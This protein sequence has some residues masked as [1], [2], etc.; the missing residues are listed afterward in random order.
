MVS[1]CIS[2]KRSILSA[3]VKPGIYIGSHCWV[4]V[5][6][7]HIHVGQILLAKDLSTSRFFGDGK[8]H[9]IG[10]QIPPI[11]RFWE[12]SGADLV[13]RNRW[14]MTNVTFQAEIF[15]EPTLIQNGVKTVL[16]EL[17]MFGHHKEGVRSIWLPSLGN[18]QPHPWTRVQTLHC[19]GDH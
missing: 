10:L 12:R 4:R 15:L 11:G 16:E 2:F 3:K 7:F 13:L 18:L 1:S 17:S 6:T 5:V 9:N 8:V 19:K 14:R